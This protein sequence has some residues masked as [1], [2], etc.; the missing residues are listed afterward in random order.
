M[1]TEPP[2]VYTHIGKRNYIAYL[3]CSHS[4]YTM[5]HIDWHL[6]LRGKQRPKHKL[7]RCSR[8]LHNYNWWDWEGEHGHTHI[9]L[10]S[11]LLKCHWRTVHMKIRWILKERTVAN[12]LKEQMKMPIWS[13]RRFEPITHT[14]LYWARSQFHKAQRQLTPHEHTERRSNVRSVNAI[15]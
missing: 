5:Y 8:G 13:G 3:P 6:L 9:I 2:L 14:P 1:N 15:S 7:H 4:H 11:P 12:G 10:L